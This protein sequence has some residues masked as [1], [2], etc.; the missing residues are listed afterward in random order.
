MNALRFVL[1]FLVV[2]T[3]PVLAAA[4]IEGH[5][6]P[7]DPIPDLMHQVD[8]LGA[9]AMS[10]PLAT[11]LGAALAFRPRR[12][13]TPPRVPAVIQTQILLAIVGAIVMLVV[14]Q[15]LARA[16]GIVGVASLIRYRAKV[17]D[18]KD[19]GVM[20]S[21]LG[22]GLAAGVGLYLLAAFATLFLLGLLWWVESIE[23]KAVNRFHLKVKAPD[24]GELK[25]GIE[26]VLRRYH[27]VF[28]LRSASAEGLTY[29]VQLPLDHRTD[30]VS[31]AILALGSSDQT[32]V[33][34]EEKKPR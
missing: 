4:E 25:A 8:T 28:E 6:D 2:L 19:A 18:P 20:L 14:G 11:A 27:A 16:F 1:S 9:A 12:S 17:D 15:S 34:W 13:G 10:L 31:N 23:P 22:V 29:E 24:P 26:K 33:E 30:S 5:P 3:L 32:A 21:C 7:S